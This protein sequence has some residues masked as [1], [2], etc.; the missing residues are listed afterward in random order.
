MS[1]EVRNFIGCEFLNTGDVVRLSA[2]A[3]DWKMGNTNTPQYLIDGLKKETEYIVIDTTP[4][5]KV[6]GADQ[7]FLSV[8]G[9][10][11]STYPCWCFEKIS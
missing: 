11:A 3:A 6:A 4:I 1:K 7:Q 8:D 9:A 10:E 2:K 5:L